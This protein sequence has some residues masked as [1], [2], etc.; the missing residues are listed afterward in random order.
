M[1][2]FVAV[3]VCFW[4][5]YHDNSK[6]HASILTKLGLKVVTVSSWLNFGRPAPPGRGSAAEQIYFGSALL[7]PARSVCV[8]LSA[9]SFFVV[10]DV[11]FRCYSFFTFIN[12]QW[13]GLY[14]N[15][16]ETRLHC[17]QR[18]PESTLTN[19]PK[20]STFVSKNPHNLY[21]RP[22]TQPSKF[23]SST[24]M[25]QFIFRQSCTSIARSVSKMT[26]IHD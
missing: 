10:F 16:S 7:L 25:G 21:L 18:R 17:Y 19:M 14:H 8:S 2:G 24:A 15:D 23:H 9:F 22:V 1:C 12:N 4:V 11:S 3:F 6:L 13:S 5:C 26:E 20:F